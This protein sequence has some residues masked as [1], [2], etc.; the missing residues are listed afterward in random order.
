MT[1]SLFFALGCLS[2]FYLLASALA[3]DKVA[4]SL[5]PMLEN[6]KMNSPM[7]RS[8]TGDV[9]FTPSKITFKNGSALFLTVVGQ[10]E[11]FGE[12]ERNVHATIYKVKN[13]SDPKLFNGNRL[14]GY[15][16]HEFP[17]KFLAVWIPVSGGSNPEMERVL[18]VYTDDTA[19]KTVHGG[20]RLCHDFRYVLQN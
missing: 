8:V 4:V 20:S 3:D 14:C 6:W 9:T 19:P 17:V 5:K 13:P 11:D 10:E 15:G 12:G 2:Y 18:G 1:Q 16:K 7:A